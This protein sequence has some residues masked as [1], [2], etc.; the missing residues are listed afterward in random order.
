MITPRLLLKTSPLF[1]FLLFLLSCQRETVKI[2]EFNF[3]KIMEN[4]N[5]AKD[6]FSLNSDEKDMYNVQGNIIAPRIKLDD[7][8]IIYKVINVNLDQDFDEEQLIL[9]KEKNKTNSRLYISLIDY[10]YEKR[11]YVQQWSDS[12]NS[13]ETSGTGIIIMDMTGD[14]VNEI[15]V[16]G[17]TS[18]REL[19]MNIYKSE[20][21][22]GSNT[23]YRK[24]LSVICNAGVEINEKE[25]SQA[26]K[27]GQKNGVPHSVFAYSREKEK[28]NILDVVK[29]EYIWNSASAV[30]AAAGTETIAGSR[31]DSDRVKELLSGDK[32]VFEAFLSGPWYRTENDEKYSGQTIIFFNT[33]EKEIVFYFDDVQEIY[34]WRYSF[35]TRLTNSLYISGQNDLVPFI[36]KDISVYVL[37]TDSILVSVSE[38]GIIEKSGQWNGTYKRLT[39]SMQQ[40]TRKESR[41][42]ETA[43]L[44]P[45]ISGRYINDKG[46]ELFFKEPKLILKENSIEK[47][48]GFSIYF[49]DRLIMEMVFIDSTGK[50]TERNTYAVEYNKEKVDNSIKHTLKLFPGILGVNGFRQK[51]KSFLWFEQIEKKD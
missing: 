10:D 46:T 23:V 12:T 3:S 33:S 20:I 1:V 39:S 2:E 19:T 17:V 4:D 41:S 31:G 9:Y 47:T 11:A 36:T 24:I 16:K 15:I 49:V 45:E 48:G 51:D 38:P 32:S 42:V 27:L 18:A 14:H 30:Y 13:E 43:R 5:Q 50:I 26:Y 28:G 34:S 35:K 22:S 21:K 7:N 44:I 37:E 8:Y 29:T 6:A 25:R 40:S